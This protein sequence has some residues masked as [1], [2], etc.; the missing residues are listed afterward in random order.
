MKE[1]VIIT[2]IAAFAAGVAAPMLAARYS[3]TC[4]E[5]TSDKDVSVMADGSSMSGDGSWGGHLA[6]PVERFFFYVRHPNAPRPKG[7]GRLWIM[8]QLEK[9]D[10]PIKIACSTQT[11]ECRT[12]M[13][14]NLIATDCDKSHRY[15]S[16][17]DED[18]KGITQ[19][20]LARPAPDGVYTIPAHSSVSIPLA[21]RS[22][23]SDTRPQK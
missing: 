1:V 23:D 8:E 17:P 3:T 9:F 7:H 10:G 6:Y 14:K 2:A 11:G 12:Q 13:P 20:G 22:G 5:C 4:Y 19:L 16:C 21:D 18:M 15:G